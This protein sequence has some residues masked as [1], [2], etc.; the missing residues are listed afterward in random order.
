MEQE[1][2][3]PRK[4]GVMHQHEEIVRPI[5]CEKIV[6]KNPAADLYELKERHHPARGCDLPSRTIEMWVAELRPGKNTRLHK[7]HNEALIYVIKGKGHSIV[8]GRRV[9]WEEGDILYIPPFNWHIHY[10]D[11][12]DSVRYLA[13]TNKKLLDILGLDRKVEAEI[14]MTEEEVQ[15]EIK[16]I[17]P[18]PYTNVIVGPKSKE[19]IQHGRPE[20]R[21]K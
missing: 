21:A 19:N 16:T 10:N 7:H 1:E 5:I 14:H 3:D 6:H 11:G 4:A 17:T 9:E 15:E 12:E 2:F 20:D 8:Q 13:V 18:S